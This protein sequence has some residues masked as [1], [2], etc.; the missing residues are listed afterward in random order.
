[1]P[2][3]KVAAE[4]AARS[5][6]HGHLDR[7]EDQVRQ[8]LSHLLGAM[9]ITSHMSHATS[10]GPADLY[11]ERYRT[12]IETKR[13]GLADAPEQP[14]GREN[15]ETPR[16]Q[17]E[18]YLRAEITDEL[19]QLDSTGR[20][21]RAWIGIVT[22]GKVWHAWRYPH[23]RGSV[24]TSIFSDW[25]PKSEGELLAD[26]ARLFEE[27]PIGKPWIPEHPA[28]IFEPYR[29]ELSAIR[30]QLTATQERATRTK[31]R[32]WLNILRTSSIAPDNEH[33]QHNLFVSHSFL[34]ALARGVVH[35]LTPNVGD[36]DPEEILREG[37]PAWI[38]ESTPGRAWAQKL[39]SKVH[40][41]EW[42]RRSGDVLRSVYETFI[43]ARDR[44]I[45][46]EYYTPDW[47]ASLL[48]KDVCDDK[49]CNQAAAAALV[50]EQSGDELF[51]CGVLDPACG[52]GTFLYHAAKRILACKT[53][54]EEALPP[55]RKASAVA[56][57]VCG[58]DIHPVA[59]EI[60]RATVLR[61]LPAIPAGRAGAL[62]I[63]QGDSL[64]TQTGA[65]DPLFS[66]T[67][68]DMRFVTPE[69]S[70]IFL[71]RAF[72][73]DRQFGTNLARLV[74]AA[75]DGEPIQE[76]ILATVA[77]ETDKAALGAARDRIE[78]IVG[79]EGNSVWS[80]YIANITAPVRLTER[81]VDRIVA[82]PPWVRMSEIQVPSRKTA[83]EGFSKEL[84]LWDGGRHATSHD[85]ARLFVK[86]CREVYL[87]DPVHDPAAWIVKK[88]AL[89]SGHW[90]S[91]RRWH[92]NIVAQT[93]DLEK[94]QPFGSGDARR[95]CVLFDVRKSATLG[96]GAS[97][98]IASPSEPIRGPASLTDELVERLNI[99]PAP[100]PLPSVKSHYAGRGFRQG[101]TIAP[102]RLTRV[103][104]FRRT[105]GNQVEVTTA[106][107]NKAPW[108]SIPPLIGNIPAGWLRTIHTST[109]MVPFGVD[110]DPGFAIIPTDA[111]GHLHS[112]PEGTNSLWKQGEA[113]WMEHRSQGKSNPETLL[114]RI[115]YGGTL[116]SQLAHGD[117]RCRTV[118]YPVSG[119]NMR[120]ARVARKSTIIAHTLNYWSATSNDEAAYLVALLNAPA[121]AFAFRESRVS[122]RAFGLKFWWHVPI[123]RYDST[124][125]HHVALTKLTGAAERTVARWM[126]T[127]AAS[128]VGNIAKSARIRELLRDDGV[129]EEIDEIARKVLPQHCV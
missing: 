11:L 68:K 55:E 1:M 82:N 26:L 76:D 52:S 2:T 35:T 123:P 99:G 113:L 62:Q 53:L 75:V 100:N 21:D 83:I 106:H 67:G 98:L 51:G 23:Q 58:L 108:K 107:S 88:A 129:F 122:G 30:G 56:R 54:Q 27:G 70:E 7:P 63:H 22:D 84:G 93:L 85:I 37:F 89:Y 50:A 86:R 3:D 46:G 120:A 114:N 43:D 66:H 110:P 38:I 48:V 9:G 20:A 28:A 29:E 24:G 103:K 42:R 117:R 25:R 49:W 60:S 102:N 18:R 5:L 41:Y 80:W 72:A 73:R 6:L 10:A 71:P 119:D 81:K 105:H 101:A 57:L 109:S 118:L 121:L 65:N 36:P 104:S 116:S 69:G 124:N 96:I 14:Q 97:A 19:G 91:F 33:Q 125:P 12:I 64:L 16:Q 111:R 128:G 44:K 47:L 115:D 15:N 40:S 94:A 78:Q 90:E 59:V 32:L 31:Q 87:A 17:L 92:K 95:C 34:I 127:S 112:N 79:K 74:N 39:L 4:A 77:E 45:F 13:V 126:T 61:A 8:N